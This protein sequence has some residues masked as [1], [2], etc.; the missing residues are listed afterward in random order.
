MAYDEGLAAMLR[1]DL[2]ETGT[3][4]E[5]RMFGGLCFMVDGH[6]V[7]GAHG[8][9]G[10]FRVGKARQA[11]AL[12]LPGVGPMVMGGRT[13]GGMADADESA[14]ANDTLRRRLIA[15]ALEFTRGLPER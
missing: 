10:M 4:V 15:M 6:M 3:L 2:A 14:M 8:G 7:A 13:M 5:K 1:D 11:V 9:G 12:A